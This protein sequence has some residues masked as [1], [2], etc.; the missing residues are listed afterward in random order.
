MSFAAGLLQGV[1]GSM[2]SRVTRMQRDRELSA[3]EALGGQPSAAQDTQ[4]RAMGVM[5]P[6]AAATRPSRG[7]GGG[8]SVGRVDPDMEWRVWNGFVERGVPEHVADGIVGN[9]IGESRLNPGINEIAPLV[10]GSRGGFGFN[11]WTGPRR[12]ALEAEAARRGVSLDDVDFQIDYTMHELQ[13]T[14]RRAYD[15]LLGSTNSEEAEPASS[16]NFLR[17]GSP[18]LEGRLA[19]A[20]RIAGARASGSFGPARQEPPSRPGRRALS[21][22]PASRE[23]TETS[24]R[25]EEHSPQQPFSW[26]RNYMSKGNT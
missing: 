25:G 12:R 13:G 21:A 24:D 16:E 1:A 3:L 5:G 8:A 19:H 7:A 17:P 11:Q 9:M 14:E 23:R 2:T 20:R 4:R 18:H 26:L 15:R 10:A 6:P 22:T